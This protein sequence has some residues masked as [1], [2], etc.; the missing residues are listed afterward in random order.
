MSKVESVGFLWLSMK[1][2][3]LLS[4]SIPKALTLSKRVPAL[5]T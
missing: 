5:E 4:F 2:Y 1:G 3:Q